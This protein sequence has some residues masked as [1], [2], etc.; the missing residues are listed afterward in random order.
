MHNPKYRNNQGKKN[1]N[2]CGTKIKITISPNGKAEAI[3]ELVVEAATKIVWQIQVMGRHSVMYECLSEHGVFAPTPPFIQTA[4]NI[5]K[6]CEVVGC[7]HY[8]AVWS[9]CGQTDVT[10]LLILFSRDFFFTW[11]NNEMKYE[12]C[13]DRYLNLDEDRLN[14]FSVPPFLHNQLHNSTQVFQL[15]KE[16]IMF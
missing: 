12:G 10:K 16:Y 6:V 7:G 3:Q 13:M 5:S 15:L 1:N 9:I 2:I 14:P 8:P 11:M 4:V